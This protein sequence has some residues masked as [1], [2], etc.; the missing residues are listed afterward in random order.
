VTAVLRRDGNGADERRELVGLGA[1]ASDEPVAVARDEERLPV[2]I[3]ACG[4]QL[5]R[6][7]QRLD[8]IEVFRARRRDGDV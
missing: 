4:R 6:D 2:L 8:R 7:E 1:A 5:A 3:D